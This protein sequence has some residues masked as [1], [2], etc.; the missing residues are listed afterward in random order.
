MAA[1]IEVQKNL[2]DA[3]I[4]VG[5]AGLLEMLVGKIAAINS[6]LANLPDVAG[7]S[8]RMIALGTVALI[9]ARTWIMR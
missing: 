5:G 2:I 8:L 7:I 1:K 4:V 3:A 6:L 9:A